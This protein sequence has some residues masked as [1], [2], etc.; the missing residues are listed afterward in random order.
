MVNSDLS[1]RSLGPR[2]SFLKDLTDQ[3][4]LNNS[5]RSM[6]DVVHPFMVLK[7]VRVRF[8]DLSDEVGRTLFKG[9]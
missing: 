2:E 6:K 7:D 3:E 9:V 5:R 4:D 8:I 1:F